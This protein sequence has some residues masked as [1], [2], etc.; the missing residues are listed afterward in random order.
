MAI[1]TSIK[2]NAKTG[3]IEIAGTE[4]F[5][6]E[7]LAA[8]KPLILG[9][10]SAEKSKA[11]LPKKTSKEPAKTIEK[12]LEKPKLLTSKK[13]PVATKAAV[14]TTTNSFK[15]HLE[16][17]QN[18]LRAGDMMLIATEFIASK[19]KSKSAGTREMTNLLKDHNVS[20]NNPSQY[21]KNALNS[22]RLAK[23][24]KKNFKL[25]T[26]GNEHLQKLRK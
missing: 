20:I 22:G 5:V 17:Y 18:N 24:G 1:Q 9:E 10:N 16:T 15:S 3:E 6:R 14:S 23:S 12:P 4:A 8:L 11:T 25:T 26:K 2:I 7:Q 19:S 13:K 21:V